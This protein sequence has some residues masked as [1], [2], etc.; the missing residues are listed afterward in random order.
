[1]KI[2]L[3]GIDFNPLINEIRDLNIH[4]IDLLGHE[5]NMAAL[6]STYWYFPLFGG[7]VFFLFSPGLWQSI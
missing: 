3:S 5:A 6:L 4:F 7:M 1:M 2:G